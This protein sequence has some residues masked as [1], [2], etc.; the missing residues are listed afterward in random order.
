MRAVILAGGKGTRLVPF[1][2]VFPKPLVPLGD[3]PI[4]DTIL[5]QLRHFGFTHITLAVGHMAEL[6]RTYVGKGERYGLAVFPD[7][8]C[9]GYLARVLA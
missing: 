1:T 4:L 2:K 9:R 8:M 3:K 5:C 6:I 7:V